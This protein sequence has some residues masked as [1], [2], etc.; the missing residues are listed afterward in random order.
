[1]QLLCSEL[2]TGTIPLLEW[3]PKVLGAMHEEG[4]YAVHIFPLPPPVNIDN[5]FYDA[6]SLLLSQGAS[7]NRRVFISSCPYN[8]LLHTPSLLSLRYPNAILPFHRGSFS[9][10]YNIHSIFVNHSRNLTSSIHLS[11]MIKP[12]E[13]DASDYLY[14]STIRPFTINALSLH[15]ASHI[16][17]TSRA[18]IT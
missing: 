12:S 10:T 14:H 5:L 2:V 13:D 16:H 4:F 8:L 15:S 17:D 11:L 18:Q 7:H 9:P 3:Q 6:H 1:M